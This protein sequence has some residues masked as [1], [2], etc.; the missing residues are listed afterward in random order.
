MTAA[1]EA[2]FNSALHR[3]DVAFA[4]AP[5]KGRERHRGAVRA[6]REPRAAGELRRGGS[7]EILRRAARDDRGAQTAQP[8]GGDRSGLHRR[9]A[10][11]G[12][13]RLHYRQPAAGVEDAGFPGRLSWRPAARYPVRSNWWP[14]TAPTNQIDAQIMLT[15]IY[16]REKEA[17]QI[18]CA[19][20]RPDRAAAPEIICC[21]SNWRKCTAT[22][23]KPAARS[24][25]STEVERMKTAHAPGYDRVPDDQDSRAAAKVG[26]AGHA[27]AHR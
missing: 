25:S 11:A 17:G 7:Q 5:S 18:D 9:A 27:D 4:G 16:R 21:A 20:E 23:G 26:T 2:E 8:G 6:G 10:D 14:N 22:W 24:K 12:V 3:R 19:A 13:E 15:A 1:E